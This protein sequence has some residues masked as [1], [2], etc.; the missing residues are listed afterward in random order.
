[1]ASREKMPANSSQRS[2][3]SGIVKDMMREWEALS[4]FDRLYSGSRRLSNSSK[5]VRMLRG[6]LALQA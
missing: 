2:G 4:A 5:F 3:Y 6:S 1:M